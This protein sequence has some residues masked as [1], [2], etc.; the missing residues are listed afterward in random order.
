M[1]LGLASFHHR[2]IDNFSQI[3]T[4]LTN[5]LKKGKKFHWDKLTQ[6]AFEKLKT[7]F[8]T[9]PILRHFDPSLDVIVETDASDHAMGGAISQ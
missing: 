6:K 4:P 2:F 3:I 8:T 5:L 7:S 9:T 1:F